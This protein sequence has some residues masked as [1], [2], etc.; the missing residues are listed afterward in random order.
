MQIIINRPI[1]P[2]SVRGP[3]TLGPAR[4]G[5]QAWGPLAI[6]KSYYISIQINFK[7]LKNI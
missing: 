7:N 3:K 5:P 1:R 4:P 2:D 6:S